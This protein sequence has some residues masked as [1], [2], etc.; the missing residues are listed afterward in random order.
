M[1]ALME[2]FFA[3]VANDS[4]SFRTKFD[5][6]FRQSEVPRP[7]NR[8]IKFSIRNCLANQIELE[9]AKPDRKRVL[10]VL[11]YHDFYWMQRFSRGLEYLNKYWFTE[12]D[13][14]RHNEVQRQAID[15][16]IRLQFVAWR[17]L[18]DAVVLLPP[19]LRFMIYDFLLRDTI[20]EFGQEP[21]WL[22]H[23]QHNIETL[24]I[25]DKLMANISRKSQ[26]VAPFMHGDRTLDD[27]IIG[28]EMHKEVILRYLQTGKFRFPLKWEKVF[29]CK[30]LW[31]Y[32]I[33]PWKFAKN[34][35]LLITSRHLKGP[36]PREEL[37]IVI[38]DLHKMF[39]RSKARRKRWIL[40]FAYIPYNDARE[41]VQD[42][43]LFCLMS[44][45]RSFEIPDQASITIR[46]C[47]EYGRRLLRQTV[48]EGPME[49][50]LDMYQLTAN[51]Q[52]LKTLD[53]RCK[54]YQLIREKIKES[55]PKLQY[56]V[57]SLRVTD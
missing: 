56:E 41:L 8:V 21:R 48:Y 33:N 20:E 40:E 7:E 23:P 45:L 36:L 43:N 31:K 32:G 30:D 44:Y 18:C 5:G 57:P 47:E 15:I 17:T 3:G 42:Q 29:T 37:Q 55:F 16:H 51:D 54:A 4:N 27:L 13:L 2:R 25:T 11:G 28:P 6:Q 38:A 50:W 34:M 35:H 24:R 19:E 9:L 1:S 39:K 26:F 14:A 49:T 10:K 52:S 53:Q 12:D 46:L 22:T